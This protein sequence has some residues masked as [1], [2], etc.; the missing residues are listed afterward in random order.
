[1]IKIVLLFLL[2]LAGIAMIGNVVTGFLRGPKEPPKVGSRAKCAH[3]GRV[4]I[5]TTPCV[6][7]KG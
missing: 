4:V 6:C 7:G 2:I 3:C 1:M 5:G